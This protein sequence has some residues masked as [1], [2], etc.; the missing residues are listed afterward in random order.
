MAYLVE[1]S[2]SDG[3]AA[4]NAQSIAPTP[5][6]LMNA[7]STITVNSKDFKAYSV[8]TPFE[9]LVN[10][11]PLDSLAAF[12]NA[13]SCSGFCMLENGPASILKV[14]G[15]NNT[16]PTQNNLNQTLFSVTIN[17][18]TTPVS[19]TNPNV[20]IWTTFG[21]NSATQIYLSGMNVNKDC[22]GVLTDKITS[23]L[24]YSS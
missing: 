20:S 24:S 14:L 11:I 4:N 16:T 6:S 10:Y 17:N 3:V 15:S 21:T 1:F 5:A 2:K 18:T 8:G 19:S 22:F 13:I 9:N 12:E 23:A 7:F